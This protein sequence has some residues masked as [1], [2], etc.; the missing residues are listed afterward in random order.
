MSLGVLGTFDG[1]APQEPIETM[2]PIEG[3][4]PRAAAAAAAAADND[5]VDEIRAA[6]GLVPLVRPTLPRDSMDPIELDS[7]RRCWWC[8]CWR[9]C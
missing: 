4:R 9:C 1:E 5:I 7:W 2:E 3:E 8:R 6:E